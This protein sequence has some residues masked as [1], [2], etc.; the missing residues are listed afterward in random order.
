MEKKRYV[1][2][3]GHSLAYRAFYALPTTLTT[4][5][6]Q[7]TN[8]VY[9]FVSMLI[10]LLSDFQPDSLVVAFDRGRPAYRLEQYAEYKAHR[11]PMPDTL[12][13]QIEIIKG[14]L[15]TMGIAQLEMEGYEAD[16][17]LATL[18]ANLDR[19]GSQAFIVT[20]DK[21]IL[22][23]VDDNVRVVANKKG[24]TD[25]VIFDRPQVIERFGV[26]PEHIADFLALKGDASDNIPGVSGVG[27]K[28]ATQLIQAYGGID[29]IYAHLDEIKSEKTRKLLLAGKEDAFLSRNLARLVAD[30]PVELDP[31][32]FLLNAWDREAVRRLFE[33]L[34]FRTLFTRLEGL[35]DRLFPSSPPVKSEKRVSEPPPAAAEVVIRDASQLA[36]LS[37][38]ARAAGTI[39]VYMDQEGAGYS[40]VSLRGLAMVAGDDSFFL[41]CEDYDL[42]RNCF[43]SLIASGARWVTHAAKDLQ[44]HLLKYGFDAPVF[45]FDSELA[46]YLLDPTSLDYRFERLARDCLRLE[47]EEDTTRQLSLDAATATDSGEILRRAHCL[48]GLE[49]VLVAR[50][51][52]V[53]LADLNSNLELPLQAVLAR[54]E[55]AGVRIDVPFLKTLSQETGE[56]LLE[57]EEEI[58][59]LAGEPFNVNSP[60]QLS[61]V[62]FEVLELPVVKKTKTGYSTDME[63]LEALAEQHPIVPLVLEVRELSKLKGTY[64]DALPRLVDPTSGRLHTSFNQTVTATGR[65]SSS[66]PNLQNIPVRSQAGIRVR[67]AFIPGRDED[68]LLVADYSQIELRILAHLSGDAGLIEAFAQDLDIHAATASEVFGVPLGQVT[69]EHRRRA[70]AINFGLLYG[71]GAHGLSRQ[72]NVT[73]AEARQYIQMYFERY[74]RVKEY[75]EEEVQRATQNGY[76]E[77]ILGRRRRL[78]ELLSP[79]GRMKSLGV[80]LAMNSPIQGSAADVIKLAMLALDDALRVE[81]LRSRLILQV[82]DELLLDTVADERDRV[83]SLVREKMEGALEISVPLRVELSIGKNWKEAKP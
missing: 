55:C 77:T 19:A 75:L 22:Q 1:L 5:S 15:E 28:T 4:S 63:V 3:D 23:L 13:E 73:D 70:K 64:L 47:L 8:A 12:R 80:R 26:P 72:I 58:H 60:Q 39:Y 45:S 78:P 7:V 50:L 38:K 20:S 59:R 74:P 35:A 21:D 82:H 71:M 66:S 76:V 27:D 17:L 79:E 29:E 48:E 14:L 16:D 62:L 18:A 65:L 46:A 34:E 61:R 31:R 11:P 33:Q 25:I 67:Q 32:A 53:N 37:E 36:S 24:L 69:S 43:H 57:L 44:L 56:R 40:G 6:G 9:G 10:K 52:E 83:A 30:L 51:N 41:D 49:Q 54:M 68:F 81:G 42:V 2:I